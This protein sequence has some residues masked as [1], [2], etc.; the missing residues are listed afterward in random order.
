MNEMTLSSR[1]RIRNS[2][3][4]GLRPS[5]GPAPFNPLKVTRTRLQIV[6]YV[7]SSNSWTNLLLTF[8]SVYIRIPHVWGIKQNVNRKKEVIFF[9]PILADREGK[10]FVFCWPFPAI[11]GHSP[12]AVSMLAHRHWRWPNIETALGECPVFAGFL[13]WLWCI[14]TYSG[15]QK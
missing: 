8:F 11:T 15:K 2:G 9:W 4:G 5:T 6:H 10:P 3:P 13:F 7:L 12:N 1:H 14:L